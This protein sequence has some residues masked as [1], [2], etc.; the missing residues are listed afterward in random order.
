MSTQDKKENFAQE[1]FNQV[2]NNNTQLFNKAIQETTETLNQVFNE[3]K[4]NIEKNITEARSQ[5]PRYTQTINEVQEQAVQATRDIAENYLEYQ[6][7]AIDSFQSAF[8]PYVEN[9]N[10][11]LWNNQGLYRKLPEIYS[12]LANNYAENSVAV[13]R[14]INNIAFSNVEL[15]KNV[16]SNT[17]EQSKQLAEIGKRS[18]SIYDSVDTENKTTA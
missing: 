15:L 9:A 11:Q 5:I 4:K 18:V 17:K 16:I 6:K 14:I 8:R 7:Q 3:S 1:N 2:V 12:K 10:N 13:S